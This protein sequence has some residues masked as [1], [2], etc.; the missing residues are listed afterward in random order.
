MKAINQTKMIT[1]GLITFFTMGFTT[2]ALAEGGKQKE[3]I[4]IR[5]LNNNVNKQPLFLL[6]VNNAEV[7]EYLVKVRDENGEVLYR[8]ILKGEKVSRKYQL[9][10]NEEESNTLFQIRFEITRLKTNETF[11]YNVTRKNT[12]IQ[13]IVVA[14]L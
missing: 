7:G 5:V 6:N 13:D 4:E 1:L 10:F 8:E 2:I 11:T 9:G 14:K 12:V 3:P